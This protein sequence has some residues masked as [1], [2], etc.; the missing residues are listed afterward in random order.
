MYRLGIGTWRLDLSTR[1][2]K[3]RERGGGTT[4]AR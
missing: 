4:A 3:E 2:S 1:G